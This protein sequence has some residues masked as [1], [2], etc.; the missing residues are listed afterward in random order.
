MAE[1]DYYGVL[2]VT[3]TASA[4][5]IRKAYRELARKY[6]PDKN[7]GDKQAEDRFKEVGQAR[8]VLL[9]E[10][11]RALYDEFGETGLRE[12][13]NADAYRQYRAYQGGRAPGQ[14]PFGRGPSIEDLFSSVQGGG[15]GFSGFGFGGEGGAGFEEL[16]NRAAQ[17]RRAAAQKQPKPDVVSDISLGFVE[18][19]TG[20]ERAIEL[21]MPGESGVREMRVRIPAGVKDGGQVRL[22]GQGV[23]GGDLVL[24]IHVEEHAFLRREDDDLHMTLPITVGEA[25]RGA[26]I[27]VPLPSGEVTLTVPKGVQSGAKLRLRGKGVSHGNQVG[28]LIVTLQLRLPEGEGE[29][30]SKAIAEVESFY[31]PSLRAGLK[32]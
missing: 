27:S 28:D 3:R 14:S 10:K 22:R 26:K 1:R 9:N 11:K 25:Y 32:L 5:E 8:D 20:G 7:P 21:R 18:A 30:L 17:R 24:R 6:H 23:D 2:G 4:G 15:G 13:F 19:L 12:G 31:G 16:L 29:A